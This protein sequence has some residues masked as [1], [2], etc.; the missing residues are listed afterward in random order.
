[1]KIGVNAFWGEVE[2]L[3]FNLGHCE[4]D[5]LG[6]QNDEMSRGRGTKYYINTKTVLGLPVVE[7]NDL[8][9]IFPS[10]YILRR[11]FVTALECTT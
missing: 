3:G 6:F 4:L 10:G 9:T 7:F 5:C 1:M 11:L 2:C 8:I